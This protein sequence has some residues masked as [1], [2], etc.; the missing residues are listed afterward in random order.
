MKG[1][2][3]S[4]FESPYP[5]WDL[6]EIDSEPEKYL[7]Y[8]NWASAYGSLKVGEEVEFERSTNPTYRYSEWPFVMKL[9]RKP[10]E[11]TIIE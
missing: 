8:H 5:W 7:V 4:F 2:V 3:V 9:R 10:K 6:L 1:K 11:G